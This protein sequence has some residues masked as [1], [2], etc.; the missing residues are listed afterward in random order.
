VSVADIYDDPEINTPEDDF[1][2]QV[3]FDRVGDRVRARVMS[4]EKITTRYGPTL[5]YMLFTDRQEQKSM[6]A[7]SKNLKAAMLEKRPRPGDVIDLTYT[8]LRPTQS[9]GDVKIFSL[10]VEPGDMSNMVPQ[11]P[12]LPQPTLPPQAAAQPMPQAPQPQ[13]VA[14]VQAQRAPDP[15]RAPAPRAVQTMEDERDIF[16]E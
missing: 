10:I 14:A 15:G 5:K 7:G 1:P 11:R 3:R 12:L 9:G 8:E 6:L 2:D 4:V 13:P 16:D